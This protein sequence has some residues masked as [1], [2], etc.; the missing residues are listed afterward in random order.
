MLFG[1][2]ANL[3]QRR[4]SLATSSAVTEY[5]ADLTSKDRAKQKAAVQRFLAERVKQDWQ[6]EWPRN[7]PSEAPLEPPTESTDTCEGQWKQ[8]DEW[9]S[10]ASEDGEDVARQPTLHLPES[11]DSPIQI[12]SS[13]LVGGALAKRANDRRRR[14][15]ERLA[16]E[17][18]WNDGVN[19]FVQRRDAWT[20][21]RH[22]SH[23][24]DGF[25]RIHKVKSSASASE[26]EGS[27]TA[28]DDEASEYEEGWETD[29][30][31]PIAGPLLPPE[32]A[33]RASITPA[34]YNTIYD[35]VIVQQLTPSCP[36]NLKDVT[37]SCVQGWKRDGEWPPRSSVPE[38]KKKQR[39]RSMSIASML[40]LERHSAPE[41][42]Q[43]VESVTEK[44][45]T[46]K[47]NQ[48]VG[49]IRR[50]LQKILSLGQ[51]GGHNEHENT[52][53]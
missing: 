36:M 26:G 44:K 17:M 2:K 27:S 3:T 42:P 1:N 29:T 15:K 40:G 35:K 10:N 6:W 49:G 32:N 16:E 51:H 13:N 47:S 25:S 30:E 20:C 14:R 12:E 53:K 41:K 19:C 31:I 48:P 22:V 34:A 38:P 18:T 23:R 28:I 8:R 24:P 4:R 7:E 50:S 33:M 39:T 43:G 9:E 46:E 45:D 5:E 21:A 11:K 37:G 52:K